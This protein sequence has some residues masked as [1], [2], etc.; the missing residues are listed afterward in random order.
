MKSRRAARESGH[1]FNAGRKVPPSKE[2]R[3]GLST[4]AAQRL[5]NEG[6]HEQLAGGLADGINSGVNLVFAKERIDASRAQREALEE[7]RQRQREQ[8]E[9]KM[10]LTAEVGELTDKD[11]HRRYHLQAERSC[12]RRQRPAPSRL[13]LTPVPESTARAT[14]TSTYQRPQASTE[15]PKR[16]AMRRWLHS[17]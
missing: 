8:R 15:W 14:T 7:E 10:T 3:S 4:R 13:Q 5:R 11:R 16:R 2:L 17:H 1:D 12:G 6:R 9:K